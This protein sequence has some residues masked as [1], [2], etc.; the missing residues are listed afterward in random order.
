MRHALHIDNLFKQIS[1]GTFMKIT[2]TLLLLCLITAST[3]WGSNITQL[4][5]ILVTA[6]AQES[7]TP[8]LFLSS[9]QLRQ[10]HVVDLSEL[11][12]QQSVT[13]TLIRKSG[14]G[15]EVSL[16]GLGK[17]NLRVL[18]DDAMIEGACGSRKDPALSHIPLM[19]VKEVAVQTGPFDVSRQGGLGG[20]VSV[21]TADPSAEESV[22]IWTKAGSFDYYNAALMMEGGNESVQALVG[23]SL[24][25]MDP[26]EDGSGN[27][28]T[29]YAPMGRPYSAEGKRQHA[30]KKQ[31]VWGKLNID[32]NE[33]HSLMLTHTYGRADDVLTPRVAVDIESERTSFT[34]LRYQAQQLCPLSDDFQIRLYSHDIQHNPSDRYRL[35]NSPS[36]PAF[37]RRFESRTMLR[38]V[39]IENSFQTA[40]GDWTLGLNHDHQDWNANAFNDQTGQLI[41][42][43]FIPQVDNDLIGGFVQWNKVFN[44]FSLR[45]GVRFDHSSTKANEPLKFSRKTTSTNRNTDQHMSGYLFAT[46]YLNDRSSIFAATGRSVRLPTGAERYLQAGPSFYGNPDL[47]PSINHE[48]DLGYSYDSGRFQWKIKGFYSDLRDFIYQQSSG[49]KSWVNIDAH[50]Y[51]FDTTLRYLVSDRLTLEAGYAWQRGRKDDQPDNN[52]DG[53]LSEI[54]PWK[55]R[56]ATIWQNNQWQLRAEWLHSGKTSNIDEDGGEVNINDWDVINISIDYQLSDHWTLHT[57]VENLLDESYA[58]ANSYEFDAVSGSGANPPIVYEPGRLFYLSIMTRW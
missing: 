56:F 51:G 29:D 2:Y 44:D 11:L 37:H 28:L 20:A 4:D 53:D 33:H 47:E 13:T 40:W 43:Q 26:Y 34:Q 27:K 55:T 15:N 45:S 1:R 19:A 58:V 38:G 49:G 42:D 23:Y 36:L 32:F 48:A 39:S 46:Y 14:Y 50:L 30:F 10:E 12:S 9:E 6:K 52:N 18:Y 7:E 25:Q 24:S 41:N 16:R 21:T 17:A 54:P 57:G 22:E 35:L 5:T 31:D 8:N 3:A